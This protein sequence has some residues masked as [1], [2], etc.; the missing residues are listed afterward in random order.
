M[1]MYVLQ[2]CL[3]TEGSLHR[4]QRRTEHDAEGQPPVQPRDDRGGRAGRRERVQ[5]EQRDGERRQKRGL[6]QLVFPAEAVPVGQE[7]S[8]Q[9]G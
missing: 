6:Q 3:G 2:R 9:R 1:L 8:P 5:R 4:T 7:E